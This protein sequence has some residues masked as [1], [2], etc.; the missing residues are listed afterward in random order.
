MAIKESIYN[1]FDWY[2]P[3]YY[4]KGKGRVKRVKPVKYYWIVE[5]GIYK[6]VLVEE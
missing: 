2:Y 3:K 6:P 5:D 4:K 1:T